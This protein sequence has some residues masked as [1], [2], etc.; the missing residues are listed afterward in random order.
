VILAAAHLANP[1][2]RSVAAGVDGER[3]QRRWAVAGELTSRYSQREREAAAAAALTGTPAKRVL[4]LAA[5]GELQHDG[6]KLPAF[7]IGN[8]STVRDWK[9]RLQQKLDREERPSGAL[10]DG[11]PRDP[12]EQLRRRLIAVA[13][14]E[15]T[16]IERQPAGQRDVETMRQIAKAVHEA[17]RFP[18]PTDPRPASQD[19]RDPATGKKG[20]RVT[21]GLAGELILAHRAEQGGAPPRAARVREVQPAA[22]VPEKPV[23]PAEW[24]HAQV[25]RISGR[26][27]EP[28]AVGHGAAVHEPRAGQRERGG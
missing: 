10:E 27:G 28:A 13:D 14:A 3:P 15:L 11:P 22:P 16:A 8:T 23:T 5:A 17:S 19:T 1:H 20:S 6:Q 26:H 25:E 2:E 21:G 12:I 4:E 7:I 18:G 24:V 9:R